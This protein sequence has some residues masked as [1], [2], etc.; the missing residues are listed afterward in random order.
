MRLVLESRARSTSDQ[1]FGSLHPTE[2]LGWE[3]EQRLVGEERSGEQEQRLFGEGRSGEQEQ[4]LF[5]EGR[6]GEPGPPPLSLGL[7]AGGGLV[8]S[9]YTAPYTPPHYR[10]DQH[11]DYRRGGTTT[12][13][14]PHC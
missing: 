13:T 4:R 14:V 5:G 10:R 7:M 9:Q 1:D 12:L 3:Q 2:G 8:Y 11:T 6:S